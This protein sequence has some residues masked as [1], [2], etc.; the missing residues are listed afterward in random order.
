MSLKK[1]FSR[2]FGRK[3]AANQSYSDIISPYNNH[4]ERERMKEINWKLSFIGMHMM[5]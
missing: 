5:R 2:K 1:I 4:R 3:N